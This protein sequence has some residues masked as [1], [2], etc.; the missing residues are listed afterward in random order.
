MASA[1]CSLLMEGG[2]DAMRCHS[3][4]GMAIWVRVSDTRQV[5]DPMG[6]GMRTIFY[7]RVIAVPDLNRDGYFFLP[8]G[9]RYFTTA[10]ILGCEK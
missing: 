9:T 3:W 1:S 5:S 7:L 6:T 8:A 10:I 4:L 2:N